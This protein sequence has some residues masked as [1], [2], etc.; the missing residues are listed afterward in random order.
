[1]TRKQKRNRF[2]GYLGIP[3]KIPSCKALLN[4]LQNN[5]VIPKLIHGV[6]HFHTE[7]RSIS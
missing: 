6:M 7:Q 5:I 4:Y 1:M 3:Y 2:A